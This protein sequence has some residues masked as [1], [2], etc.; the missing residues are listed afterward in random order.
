MSNDIQDRFPSAAQA[1]LLR[2]HR[3][4]LAS[5]SGDQIA[6]SPDGSFTLNWRQAIEQIESEQVED[7][8]RR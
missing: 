4:S 6:I 7:K 8:R 5:T 3:W 1:A 2:E